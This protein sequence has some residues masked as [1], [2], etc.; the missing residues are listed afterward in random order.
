MLK[1][2]NTSCCNEREQKFCYK[3]K[4]NGMS[5]RFFFAIAVIVVS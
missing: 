4:S 2:Y 1:E 3:G 5:M